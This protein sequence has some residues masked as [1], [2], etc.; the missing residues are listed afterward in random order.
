MN[1]TYTLL[2]IIFVAVCILAFGTYKGYTYYTTQQFIKHSQYYE[3]TEHNFS[4]RFPKTWEFISKDADL[5]S[6]N[7]QFLVGVNLVG[8]P[9]TAVGVIVQQRSNQDAIDNEQLL[10]DIE[11]RLTTQFT[12]FQLIKSTTK[13]KNDIAMLDIEYTK[14][15]VDKAYVH[16]RQRIMVTPEQVYIVSG[17]SLVANYPQ[18]QND[19]H[20]ILDSFQLLE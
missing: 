3:D 6:R 15:H 17:S 8:E 10:R 7:Q 20:H 19:I 14:K 16:Q 9:S 18:Q 5:A 13:S 11:Q 2:S 12:D 1:R 4:F